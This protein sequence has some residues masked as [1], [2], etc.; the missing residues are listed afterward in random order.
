MLRADPNNPMNSSAAG[1][2]PVEGLEQTVQVDITASNKT[3]VLQLE[4]GFGEPRAYEAPFYP[5]VPTTFNYRLFGTINNTTVDF[6]I[7]VHPNGR[8]W[9][10]CK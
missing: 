10:H 1:A 7:F 2:S 9:R 3:K 4:P 6:F 8:S 5:T